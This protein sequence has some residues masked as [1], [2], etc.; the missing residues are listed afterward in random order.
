M[1]SDKAQ[2]ILVTAPLG[3]GGITSMMINIQKNLDGVMIQHSAKS[4]PKRGEYYMDLDKESLKM[5][6][7]RFI[8]IRKQDYLI[9]RSKGIL[10]RMGIY[11]I[12]KKII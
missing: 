8:P 2:H 1:N 3:F 4:H 7:Q 9:E 10:Y 11:K 5:H 6:V 12:L